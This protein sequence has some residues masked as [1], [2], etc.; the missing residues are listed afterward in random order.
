MADE[1]EAKRPKTTEAE[2]VELSDNAIWWTDH[3][4]PLGVLQLPTDTA[5]INKEVALA[6]EVVFCHENQQYSLATFLSKSNIHTD[7]YILAALAMVLHKMTREE[8]F[9]TS[10]T[11]PMG[12]IILIRNDFRADMTVQDLLHETAASLNESVKHEIHF[13][14]IFRAFETKTD[15]ERQHFRNLFTVSLTTQCRRP[16][17]TANVPETQWSVTVEACQN[18]GMATRFVVQYDS[19]VFSAGRMQAFLRQLRS[20]YY[21]VVAHSSKK[22]S[23]CTMVTAECESK[24]PNPKVIL[25]DTWHGTTFSYLTKHATETPDRPLIVHGD[26][27][28]TYKQVEELSNRVAHYL[29]AKGIQKEERVALYAHRSSALVVGIMGILKSGATFTV[30]DP[31]YPVSRQNV[32]LEVAQPRAIITLHAAG[33]LNAEVQEY[34]DKELQL[35]CQLNGLTL[36]EELEELSTYSTEPCGVEIGPDNIG[37]LSFTSGSTGKPKAVRGRHISLTHFYPWMSQEFGLSADD[38]FSMLSG[39]AHDPI[40]RD[41]F[42]PIF[43]GATIHIPDVEDI[44]NPGALAKWV[45]R[46]EVTVTHLTPAMGQLLTANATTSMPS[47][48][49][50][51]FVGDVLTKRD[52]KRL[53]RLAPNLTAVNMYGTTETQRA[54]SYLKIPN[55]HS[56]NMFKEILPSGQGM[57]DVQL[58]VLTSDMKLAGIGELAELY[59]RSPHLSAGYLGLPDQTAQKFLTNPFSNDLRDRLYRTGDLGRFLPN[60][61]VECIGRADDQVKIRGFRIELGEI[62]T[63]LGQHPS[64]RENKTLVMRDKYEEK[65]IISFFVPQEPDKYNISELRKH[66]SQRLPQYAVPSVFYPL[67]VMPLTPNGKIDKSRLPYPDTA[68]MLLNRT[69]ETI[70]VE[71]TQ[72]QTKIREVFNQFLPGPATLHDNFFEIGGHSIL[73]TKVTFHLREVLKQDIAINLLYQYPTIAKLAAVIEELEI[74]G[75]DLPVSN[76][77][78]QEKLDIEAETALDPSI[79]PPRRMKTRSSNTVLLTGATGFLGSFLLRE[80]LQ[81]SGSRRVICLVRSKSQSDGVDRVVDSL[82]SYGLFDQAFMPRIEVVSGD[83]GLPLLGLSSQEFSD[84][85]ARIDNIIHNGAMVHWVY[86]YSKLKAVNVQGTVEI[87]RLS[88]SGREAIPLYF[89]SSTSVFDSPHY[90]KQKRSFIGE[91]APLEAGD[92]LTVGYGQSKWVAEQLLRK[93]TARGCPITIFRPGYIVG[94]SKTGV[95]NLDDYIVRLIKGCTQLGLAPRIMNRIN[96]CTVD[97]VAEGIVQAMLTTS[98]GVL[99]FWQPLGIS[100]KTIF[101]FMKQCGFNV[102]FTDYTSWRQALMDMTLAKNDNALYPLLHFVMDD[103][104]T[105]SQTATLCNANTRALLKDKPVW[106]RYEIKEPTLAVLLAFLVN[107]GYLDPPPRAGQ[108]GVLP[109][110]KLTLSE[111][112]KIKLRADTH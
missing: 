97:F 104:P 55:D 93:A 9:A 84:L 26:K 53:Q 34:I 36:D 54:V 88:C 58:L 94:D 86:P 28:Y 21:D 96:M 19:A 100:I 43:L 30:I 59:V 60:G 16:N 99:H 71:M 32:Y 90:V 67:A 77:Q 3:V 38:R 31:A 64:V 37:T 69:Q 44:V 80:L 4:K 39:I 103:L 110:P 8:C 5:R 33:P 10:Y 63:Y 101:S 78:L 105:R 1:I 7:V 61:A 45:A 52:V 66:L 51:L 98:S 68:I 25:D 65:Q 47:L 108:Q 13:D 83:L 79:L 72:L 23:E 111:D 50:A 11:T 49:V 73:A 95:M 70:E 91:D 75:R 14:T 27:M 92:Q 22:V 35:R 106:S 76:R 40:Q 2:K 42:T 109:L 102:E 20:A 74:S 89:V 17:L 56:I 87:I 107:V 85:A 48:R 62:D 18:S 41:V 15:E 46:S 24:L 112:V 6:E 57:K 82:K 12:H 29:I 81:Q